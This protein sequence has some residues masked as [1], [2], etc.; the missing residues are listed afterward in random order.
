MDTFISDK[1]EELEK[2]KKKNDALRSIFPSMYGDKE[3]DSEYY[4]VDSNWN[5][6]KEPLLD[7]VF[8]KNNNDNETKTAVEQ[9]KNSLNM[10]PWKFEKFADHMQKGI[11]VGLNG[12]LDTVPLQRV[13]YGDYFEELNNAKFES[14]I[15]ITLK[16]EGVYSNSPY[17]A[18]G[19]TKYG[20]TKIFYN[21]YKN[22]V[23]GIAPDIK[24]L[25][26]EDAKKLY[27]AHWDRYNLGYIRDKRKAMLINDYT[28]NSGAKGVIERMQQ[29]LRM[30]GYNIIANGCMDKN[31]LEAINDMEFDLF[32]GDI[33]T[34]RRNNYDKCVD[35]RQNNLKNIKGWMNRLNE[36][37]DSVGFMKKYKSKYQFVL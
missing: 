32:A 1:R 8:A 7:G 30:R 22:K 11:K 21:D 20:I 36:L 25:T 29:N 26:L 5:R 34:D 16:F 2:E 27:K 3:D 33:Q 4:L 14:V 15:P 17:D 12:R 13:G 19:E 28:I 10:D 6:S 23:P 9:P 18:G 35:S 31:T 24:S 37:S